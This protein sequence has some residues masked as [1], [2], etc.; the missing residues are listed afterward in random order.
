MLRTAATLPLLL[1]ACSGSGAPSAPPHEPAAW[2]GELLPATSAS[3][4]LVLARLDATWEL[5]E[6]SL[7]SGSKE[8]GVFEISELTSAAR[9]KG[10]SFPTPFYVPEAQRRFAPPGMKVMVGDTVLD[11]TTSGGG[12]GQPTWRFD[13]ENMVVGFPKKPEMVRIEAPQVAAA[14]RRITWAMA[15]EDGLTAAE[16]A[17]HHVSLKQVSREG[18]L[19]PAPTTATWAGVTLPADARFEGWVAMA[20][21]PVRAGSDG[22][23]IEVLVRAGGQEHRVLETGVA[24]GG[25]KFEHLQADLSDWA[26][27][28]VDLV[29]RTAPGDTV[30]HDYVFVGAPT[31]HGGA[32]S[33]VRR[34]VVIGLDTTRPD[35]FQTHGAERD[36]APELDAW[37]RS[38]VVFDNAWTTAP[39]TRPSFRSSTTGRWPLDAVCAPT[40]GEVFNDHGWATA[41]VVANIHLNPR[42]GFDKGFDLWWLDGT[43]KVDDQVERAT[44]WLEEN[45]DRDSYLFLHIMDPHIFYRAP[46]PW[47]SRFTQE[48]P[49]LKP[50]EKLK[51]MFNRSDV[52]AWDRRGNLSDN[53][54][55]WIE[56]LYDGE[57]AYTSHHLGAFLEQLEELPGHTL[58]VI[59]SDHGEEFWEHGAF[60]HNHTLYDDTTRGL[61]WIRPPGGT[62][63]SSAHAD[64]PASLVDI[65]PTLYRFAGIDD[66][67]PTD[68]IDLVAAMRGEA[69]PSSRP[70]PIAHVRYGS[71]RWGVVAD[72]HKYILNTGT[73]AEELFE[74]AADPGEQRNLAPSTDTEPF[75][76][77]MAMSHT[78]AVSH[79]WRVHLT[80]LGSDPIVVT[81]PAKAVTAG[82]L[83]PEAVT[84]RPVN[85]AW[86]ERPRW[87]PED[88]ATTALSDDGKTLEIT[89]GERGSGIVYVMFE[90]AT[91]AADATV[92]LAGNALSGSGARDGRSFTEGGTTIRLQPGVVVVPPPG[93]A[94]RMAECEFGGEAAGNEDLEL[95]KSLGYIHDEG[96]KAP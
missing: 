88:V 39:R 8:G 52:A 23:R 46:E 6:T 73:G 15:R 41:G 65:G 42:F 19:L 71:D 35:H 50:A 84:G 86:G 24:P 59:H 96:D 80:G 68:G 9:G 5:P 21:S 4:A 61:L 60:E 49:P 7:P 93:E 54:K 13:G 81:L 28:E 58:V 2:T 64:T 38:A 83:D 62:G 31:V 76:R 79:G 89:P 70:L 45:Q 95:L 30:D 27:Q 77:A 91:P 56:A 11:F 44:E 18:L 63:A 69:E 67:P 25:R 66:A 26:G 14:L 78:I 16:F 92:T 29:I 40:I 22:A 74:L 12:G 57:L 72:G 90:Q 10:W 32:S 53:R 51:P 94:V 87:A 1:A 34:I 20:P 37:A 48:L 47:G 55:A 75:W 85:Q 33:D 3:E 43:A 82:A 36:A 17:R